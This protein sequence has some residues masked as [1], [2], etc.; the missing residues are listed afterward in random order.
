MSRCRC[1]FFLLLFS[2][3]LL[4]QTFLG[5]LSGTVTDM[6][7]AVIPHAA[8]ALLNIETGIIQ[9]STTD[10][11]GRFDFPELP[12]GRYTLTIASKGFATR[13]IANINIA[14]SKV[15][16]LP[17]ELQVGQQNTVITVQANGV[18]LDTTSSALVAVINSKAVLDAPLNGRDFTE[19]VTLSA[20]VNLQDSVNG[21]RTNSIN[22]QLDGA[23]NNDP[24]G[25]GVSSNQGGVADLAGGLVPID[26]I[27]QFSMQNN[28]E[29]DMGRNSGANVNVVL[30]SGTNQIHGDVYDFERNEYFAWLS[31]VALPGSRAPEIRN[32]QPGFTLGG[33]IRR[34]HTF[35]FLAGEAQLMIA[36]DSVADTVLS[37]AWIGAATQMLA[38]HRLLPNPV[39][40]NLYNSLFPDNSKGGPAA[41]GNYFSQAQNKFN[42]FNSVIKLDQNF[43]SKELLSIRYLGTTGTQTADTGSHYEEYFQ[44]APMHVFNFS[45]ALNSTISSKLVNVLTL[46]TGYFLQTFNDADQ[47]FDTQALGLNLGLTGILT[48]GAPD[49]SVSGFDYTGATPPL[50]RT[51]VTGQVTDM[52]SWSLGKHQLKLGGEFRHINIDEGY[53]WDG[54]GVFTFDGT[55]GPW[56]NSDCAAISATISCSAL[57]SVADFLNGQPTN[58]GGATI[59]RNDPERIYLIDT[60][61]AWAQDNWHISPRL[62]LNYGVRFSY[63]GVVSDSKNSLYNFDPNAGFTPEPLYQ[64]NFTGFAPRTGFAFTPF[65]R[66]ARTVIRGGYGWFY[67]WP[68]IDEFVDSSGSNTGSMGIF[69]NPAGPSPVYTITATNV[70]F[71]SGVLVFPATLGPAT[72]AG[73]YSINKNFK[74]AYLQNFNLNVERQISPSTLATIGYV[75]S[76]GR[77]LGVLYDINQPIGGVYPYST[78]YP[79]LLSINQ[80]NSAANSNFSS[81]QA[82]LRQSQW[83]G[84]SATAYYTWGHSMDDVSKITTPMNSYDLRADYGSSDFDVRNMFTGFASYTIPQPGH[85]APRLTKGWQTNGR[86]TFQGGTPIKLLAGKNISGTGENLDRPNVVPGVPVLAGRTLITTSSART[87]QYLNKAA[88]SSPPTSCLCYGDVRR[89]SVHGPGFGDVDFSVFKDTPVTERVMSQFRVEI[90]N[91]DNQADFKNPS[92][93]VSSSSFGLLTQTLNGTNIPGI[94]PGEPRNIQFALKLSF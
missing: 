89:G 87:Y 11:V 33:P 59:L 92:G 64:R 9:N 62:T 71:Q 1:L 46:A 85:F 31:P 10:G 52:L 53:Y 75:G 30:R 37:D 61:D 68:P 27:D 60:A 70:T 39:S 90:F 91:L 4:A 8:V 80:V 21:A 41:A 66:D 17:I 86:W 22:Y 57:E 94:G 16:N 28:A 58:S 83:H 26:A 25:N 40:V 63:P 93:K 54:R 12:V 78:A 32:H 72:Q 44:A 29:A 3:P 36:N 18:Q 45:V 77:H 74:N 42:S 15:T 2:T 6:S 5:E 56:T 69:S 34:N 65:T 50:F 48:H 43:T 13:Q 55:R 14:V 67:D 73:G 20:G 35:L 79:N 19:L 23:D 49:I 84:I 76:V 51:D 7:K 81:L 82:S 47:N 38:L 24:W 88:F